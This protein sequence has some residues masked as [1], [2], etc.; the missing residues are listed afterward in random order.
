MSICDDSQLEDARRRLDAIEADI[1]AEL[2]SNGPDLIT[3]LPLLKTVEQ[4]LNNTSSQVSE[5]ADQVS[6]LLNQ[7]K[8]NQDELKGYM[9]ELDQVT[10]MIKLAQSVKQLLISKSTA[11]AFMDEGDFQN[12]AAFLGSV[13][14]DSKKLGSITTCNELFAELSDMSVA[15]QKLLA[16]S[17]SKPR[18][19]E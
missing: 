4:D 8:R 7:N 13:L 9:D 1:L 17:S 6:A 14:S 15:V 16:N 18:P 2:T 10:D 3:N 11:K 19:S 12:A 5:I